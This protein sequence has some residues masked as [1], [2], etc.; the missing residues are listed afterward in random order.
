MSGIWA[1]LNSIGVAMELSGV[2]TV[3]ITSIIS[4]RPLSN[5]AQLLRMD[6]RQLDDT[7]D[8]EMKARQ[9]LPLERAPQTMGEYYAMRRRYLKEVA[10]AAL[11]FF[12]LGLQVVASLFLEGIV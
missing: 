12:G 11:L 8:K 9:Q 10:G 5:L 4:D 1:L 6:P 2:V 3:T 7:E